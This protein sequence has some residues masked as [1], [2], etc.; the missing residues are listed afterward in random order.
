[1]RFS[2]WLKGIL[3]GACRMAPVMIVMV[4]IQA[5][6]CSAKELHSTN[7]SAIAL[8]NEGLR[9]AEE[10]NFNDALLKLRQAIDSD[11]NFLEA[12]LRYMDA[13]KGVGR[14]EEV[15]DMYGN[16]LKKNPDSPLFHFLY[17]RTVG[18]MNEKR[19]EFRK[20]LELDPQFYFAQYG[21]GGSYMIEGRQDEAI[22][23]LNRALE[24]KPD[25]VD[26]LVLQG[27]IYLD[28]GMPL[29]ARDLLEKAATIDTANS[30]IYLRLGQAYSQMERFES[31]EKAF[32]RAQTISPKEPMIY[33]YLGLVSEMSG[34][35]QAAVDNYQRFVEL[36]PDHKF[37]SAVKKTLEKLKR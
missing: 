18:D 35:N 19:A 13:F 5:G 36:A 11:P 20:A 25:M 37:V 28:K 31:A 1:M 3:A 21:I 30:G 16:L 27:S 10:E 24:M 8:Y 4:A 2:V 23:A 14:G 7:S 33:Y 6:L 9:L 22:V 15:V 17:G 26:A 32:Y 29:Q 12:H 34:K